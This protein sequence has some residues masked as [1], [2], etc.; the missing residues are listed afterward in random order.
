MDNSADF[1][2]RVWSAVRL[3][4]KRCPGAMDAYRHGKT[5]L[6]SDPLPLALHRTLF[7][8]KRLILPAAA[9]ERFSPA[10]KSVAL[11]S[12]YP[13]FAGEDTPLNDMLLLLTLAKG[14]GAKR[15]LEI[16]TYRA[17][18]T[19]A[20]HLNCPSAEV[21]SYDIQVLPSA[22]RD[23]VKDH[24][25][26][27]LRVGSFSQAAPILRSEAKYDFIFIDGSHRIEDVVQDS[28]LAFEILGLGGIIVWHDYR[29]NGYSTVE[30]QVPEG[31]EKVRGDRAIF[32]VE[33]TTCAVYEST[34]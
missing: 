11:P 12:D 25:R 34:S 23:Q 31:L 19:L 4:A 1:E 8:R 21:V 30:L 32:A 26:V 2:G 10:A 29:Y 3:F 5:W 7:E 15:I 17:R 33:G 14:R 9:P 22:F 18:T 6:R 13:L 27:S 24:P 16:G 20:F 28:L